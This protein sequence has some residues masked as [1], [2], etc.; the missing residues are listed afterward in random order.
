MQINELRI[1]AMAHMS[2]L[3]LVLHVIQGLKANCSLGAWQIHNRSLIARP[4]APGCPGGCATT[5]P[6]V[7][8]GVLPLT[9]DLS[10]D[11]PAR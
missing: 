8:L 5:L 1:D 3:L 9:G 10:A 6:R 7:P 2:P 11:V 4:Q